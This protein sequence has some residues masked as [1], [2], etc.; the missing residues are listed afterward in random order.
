MICFLW[1]ICLVHFSFLFGKKDLFYC[2]YIW[3]R[4]QK[5]AWVIHALTYKGYSSESLVDH[6][7]DW[8]GN[9][10]IWNRVVRRMMWPLE[11]K[12]LIGPC[13]LSAGSYLVLYL[14]LLGNCLM[15]LIRLKWHFLSC[16]YRVP[17]T[18]IPRFGGIWYKLTIGL[19]PETCFYYGPEM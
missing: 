17:T 18:N 5:V 12:F 6:N 9:G 15:Y 7:E 19:F 1:I 2:N 3:I 11:G 10:L 13:G 8:F 14:W 4:W 16:D